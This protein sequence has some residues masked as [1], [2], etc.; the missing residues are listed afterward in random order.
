[1]VLEL[2]DEVLEHRLA[3]DVGGV[4]VVGYAGEDGLVA[5]VPKDGDVL[6]IVGPLAVVSRC[7]ADVDVLVGSVLVWVSSAQDLQVVSAQSCR[8]FKEPRE[9]RERNR[10]TAAKSDTALLR[11]YRLSRAGE[12]SR[13]K[14]VTYGAVSGDFLVVLEFRREGTGRDGGA[15]GGAALC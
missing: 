3:G 1:V 6:S 15:G 5:L 12:N 8:K 11:N 7:L 14:Y 13:G 2:V 10:S 9:Y 4:A